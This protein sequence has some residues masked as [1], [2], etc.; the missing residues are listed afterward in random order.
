ML[1]SA[2]RKQVIKQLLRKHTEH[3]G[4]KPDK[5]KMN[6]C[7]PTSNL[8]FRFSHISVHLL[9]FFLNRCCKLSGLGYPSMHIGTFSGQDPA[10]LP[11]RGDVS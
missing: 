4:D 2:L 9:H 10:I 5:D 7:L 8:A 1:L 11:Y 3:H 6:H